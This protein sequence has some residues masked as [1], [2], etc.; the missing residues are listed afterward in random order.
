MTIYFNCFFIILAIALFALAILFAA[1]PAPPRVIF[2]KPERKVFNFE[3][4]IEEFISSKSPMVLL[5]LTGI[6]TLAC[7][8]FLLK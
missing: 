2:K 8:I 1:E 4:K 3:K 6:T 7:L 5:I